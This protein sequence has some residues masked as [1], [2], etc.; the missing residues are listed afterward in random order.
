MYKT[1][2]LIILLFRSFKPLITIRMNIAKENGTSPLKCIL[3]VFL[4][5][6]IQSV[7]GQNTNLVI[8]G[9]PD[10]ITNK[11][12]PAIDKYRSTIDFPEF[13]DWHNDAILLNGGTVIY[14]MK[15]PDGAI[16]NQYRSSSGFG[17]YPS[18]DYSHYLSLKDTNGDENYQLLLYP[19]KT[20]IPIEITPKGTRSTSPFW[21]P[22]GTQLLYKS[23]QRKSSETDLYIRN[24]TVP[25]RDTL[26]L[27]NITDEAV[28]YDW[29]IATNRI[30][31]TKIIS[32]NDKE[33]Y[34][35]TIGT[36]KL[37]QINKGQNQIAYSNAVFLPDTDE[38]VIVCDAE[39]EYLQLFLYNS[40]ENTLRKLT[41]GIPWDID[42]I[43][44]SENKKSL[45]F[46]VNENGNSTLYR[47]DLSDFTYKRATNLP[48]GF[49]R[50][51]KSNRHGNKAAFN[52]YGSTFKRKVYTYDFDKNQLDQW[53]NK[54]GSKKE[55]PEFI[56]AIKV[57]I[58]AYDAQKQH[59]YSIPA[60]YYAPKTTGKSPVYI[61]IHG[62]PE[63]QALPQFNKWYQYLVQELGIT[64]LVPNI[65]GSNGYGKSFMKADD[66]TQREN[67][68]KDIGILLNWIAAQP[69]FDQERI[70]LFGESYGGYIVLAS[71]AQYSNKIRCGIDVVGISN[72][73]TYLEKTADYRKDLRRVEFGD[74]RLPEIRSFLENSSPVTNAHKISSPLFI[75]QGYNDPR[76][77][78]TVSEHMV[79]RLQS[80]QKTV[81]Y[82]GAKDEG[83]GFRKS[84]NRN[85]QK[86]AEILFLKT[87]LLP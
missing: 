8:T 33:L 87:F 59:T 14:K 75:I 82:L 62:G 74:E 21:K 26:L 58:P 78:Y 40:K 65:R 79:S 64:V 44:L 39:N 35:Y 6:I 55:E 49:I 23:N 36:D 20:G 15:R 84:G 63:Y 2:R 77:N 19:V 38:M 1:S 61:D 47:M 25:Y 71:L 70:A 34:C 10:T 68:V 54:K 22:D 31:F 81:W 32:E 57:N 86:N 27:K 11:P 28:I 69:Q 51:L 85:Y 83:H 12:D 43:A 76:V 16:K 60:F 17:D 53:I 18:P 37:R 30:L 24:T 4:V 50:N 42:A 46:T 67:A 29:D 9:I 3:L 13:I 66:T 7:S 45:L 73:I 41:S 48:E 56:P 72:F 80:Q 5:F 52:F